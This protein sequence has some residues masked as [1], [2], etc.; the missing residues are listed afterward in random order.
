QGIKIKDNSLLEKYGNN[1]ELINLLLIQKFLL[2]K[3]ID[4]KENNDIDNKFLEDIIKNQNNSINE[5]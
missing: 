2:G 5:S 1:T 3:D 4:E